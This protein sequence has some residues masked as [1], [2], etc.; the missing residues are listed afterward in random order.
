MNI[1]FWII[2]G[3]VALLF[4]MT[5]IMKLTRSKEQMGSQM[6]WTEDF[7]QPAIRVIGA[8]EALAAAGLIFPALTGILP[9]LTPL[10]AAGLALV[11]IGASLTHFRR[12]EYQAIG[13]TGVLLVLA[14]AVAVG[15]FWVV[16]L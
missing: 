6:K 14:L 10:A 8:L 7:S 11:M 3:V 12:K 15:R 9:W 1:V 4:L 5:G 13:M 2:Q 16:P